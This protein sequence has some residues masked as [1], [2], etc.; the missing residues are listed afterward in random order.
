MPYKDKEKERAYRREWNKK[1]RAEHRDYYR[2]Y[3]KEYRE[4]KKEFNLPCKWDMKLIWI[5]SDGVKY[6]YAVYQ[7]EWKIMI[8]EYNV[9][10]NFTGWFSFEPTLKTYTL[11]NLWEFYI[12]NIQEFCNSVTK[13]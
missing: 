9:W 1:W 12:K 11:E 2:N 4:R 13:L 3:N 10:M 6:W 8:E 5:Y 7:W